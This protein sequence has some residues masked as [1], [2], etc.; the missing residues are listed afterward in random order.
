MQVQL[1]INED[2]L[3]AESITISFSDFF[4]L[5]NGERDGF[6]DLRGY[7]NEPERIQLLKRMTDTDRR[8]GYFYQLI[9][10]NR[11]ENICTGEE[12]EN[13]TLSGSTAE[14]ISGDPA[15]RLQIRNGTPPATVKKFLVE[16]LR[17]VNKQRSIE[18]DEIEIK[19]SL[20]EWENIPF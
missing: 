12:M 2:D 11:H 14:L 15:I 8:I 1:N 18:V 10:C 3:Q 16:C 9:L 5:L 17:W 13:V 4:R 6:L 19:R 7:R 20:I